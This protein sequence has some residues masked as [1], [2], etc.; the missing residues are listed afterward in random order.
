LVSIIFSSGACSI[1]LDNRDSLSKI[2]CS[3]TAASSTNESMNFLEKLVR[4]KDWV[5]QQ[6]NGFLFTR[7]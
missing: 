4:V 7:K 1:T 6:F 5:T 3:V 2:S